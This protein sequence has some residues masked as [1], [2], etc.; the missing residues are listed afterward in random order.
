MLQMLRAWVVVCAF[1]VAAILPAS[2]VKIKGRLLA[3]D[4]LPD[5]SLLPANSKV[6]IDGGAT[7][8]FVD[9]DGT[10]AVDASE[11]SHLLEVIAPGFFFNKVRL[12]VTG[13][14]VQAFVHLDGTSWA[15]NGPSL[16]VPLE[17]PCRAQFNYFTP[18]EGF[19]VMS[20]LS[21]PMILMM[22]GSLVMFFVLPKMMSGIDPET[23]KEMQQR[24]KEQKKV[25][26]PD[27]SQNLANWL[28]PAPSSKK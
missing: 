20:I 21:N 7:Y 18:R 4:A 24:Q 17:L 28:A 23:L 15:R 22:G 6:L 2:A 26:L 5:L 8:S 19:D 27:I 10:F 11:G 3:S 16:D 9:D 12:S 14:T 1:I 13:S 25:E